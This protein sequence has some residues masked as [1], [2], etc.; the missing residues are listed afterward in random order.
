MSQPIRFTRGS[1]NE[2]SSVPDDAQDRS[3]KVSLTYYYYYYVYLRKDEVYNI[4]WI[5]LQ[6]GGKDLAGEG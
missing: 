3:G 6:E 5:V 1:G 4:V 2:S